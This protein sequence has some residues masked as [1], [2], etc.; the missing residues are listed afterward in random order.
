VRILLDLPVDIYGRGWDHLSLQA[1]QARFHSAVDARFL[2]SIYADTQFLLNTSPNVGSGIHER[3]AYGLDARC[4]VVSD[5]N[6]FSERYLQNIPTFKGLDFFDEEARD[7]I[8]D[9]YYSNSDYT[10]MTDGGVGYIESN[11]GALEMML[12][13]IAVAEE[14]RFSENFFSS[15]H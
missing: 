6:D 15:S 13:L 14:L 12:S 11:L 4:F 8:H 1:R 2:S 9:L 3:V 7:C 10:D 5:Q